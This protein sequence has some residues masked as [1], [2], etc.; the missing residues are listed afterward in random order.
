MALITLPII[1]AVS[2]RPRLI[3][4]DV[5]LERMGGGAVIVAPPY[6]IWTLSI[7]LA[8][9]TLS[10]NARAWFA[11]LAQLSK[12]SNT[13]KIMPPGYPGTGTGYTGAN[14]L[15]NGAGQLGLALNADGYTASTALALAGDF[16]EV[17]G[18]FK[19]LTAD[20]IS[21]GASQVTFNFEPALRQAPADNAAIEIKT[22]KLTLRL[23]Q[24]IAEWE[25]RRT[26]LRHDITLELV[27]SF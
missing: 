24:P 26:S 2:V 4:G 12:L 3:R 11:A 15:V 6:A 22:P 14:G 27:E 13:C 20:A 1:E 17:N 21:N 8:T 9:Q 18:E 7:P 16:L 5:P 25:Y 23:A 19:V 10:G